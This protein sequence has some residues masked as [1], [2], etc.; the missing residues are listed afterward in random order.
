MIVF[1]NRCRTGLST[2]RCFCRIV[3]AGGGSFLFWAVRGIAGMIGGMSW[4][5]IEGGVS[6]CSLVGVGILC[7][8]GFGFS[9]SRFGSVPR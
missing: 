3:C 4:V 7:G 2:A 1:R 8:L 9:G 6:R 5:R